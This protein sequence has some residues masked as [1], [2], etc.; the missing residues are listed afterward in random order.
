MYVMELR[1]VPEDVPSAILTLL[2]VPVRFASMKDLSNDAATSTAPVRKA[3]C[4]AGV[5]QLWLD[6]LVAERGA[7]AMAALR[8]TADVPS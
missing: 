2:A 3:A 4:P 6:A 7:L 1:P 8:L 5:G